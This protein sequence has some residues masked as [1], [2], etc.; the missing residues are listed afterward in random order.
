MAAWFDQQDWVER[1]APFGAMKNMQGVQQNNALMNPDGSITA[2]GSWVRLPSLSLM[3][4]ANGLVHEQRINAQIN[5]DER[6]KVNSIQHDTIRPQTFTL[7]SNFSRFTFS[8]SLST[9]QMLRFQPC[10]PIPLDNILLGFIQVTSNSSC[11]EY[12]LT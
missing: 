5:F 10:F 4:E 12:F 11:A 9:L 1:Y 2:L 6:H 3:S 7:E 8:L